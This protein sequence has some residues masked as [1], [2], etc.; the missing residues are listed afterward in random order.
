MERIRNSM[1][2]MQICGSEPLDFILAAINDEDDDLWG[3]VPSD[4]CPDPNPNQC[5]EN[6]DKKHYLFWM[7]A[8]YMTDEEVLCLTSTQ[9]T[10]AQ[11]A[12]QNQSKSSA[13][14]ESPELE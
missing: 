10:D 8:F 11:D 12:G 7:K 6:P 5:A 4:A 14:T 1:T 3:L 9:S 2:T 13:S